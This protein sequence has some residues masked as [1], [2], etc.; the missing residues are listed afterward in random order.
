MA[1]DNWRCERNEKFNSNHAIFE[2]SK[3]SVTA[4]ECPDNPFDHNSV[5]Y[6]LNR[7]KRNREGL[8]MGSKLVQK[9]Q[10]FPID[11]DEIE[12]SADE[13]NAMPIKLSS[14]IKYHRPFPSPL[15][16]P[17]FVKNLSFSDTCGSRIESIII[18]LENKLGKNECTSISPTYSAETTGSLNVIKNMKSHPVHSNIVSLDE[19]SLPTPSSNSSSSLISTTNDF[20]PNTKTHEHCLPITRNP[21]NSS[22]QSNLWFNNLR[23]TKHTRNDDSLSEE[24]SD[25]SDGQPEYGSRLACERD[26]GSEGD[27]SSSDGI[28]DLLNYDFVEIKEEKEVH[29]DIKDEDDAREELSGSSLY[30]CGNDQCDYSSQNVTSFHDHLLVC[31]FSEVHFNCYHCSHIFEDVRDLLE[32][33]KIHGAKRFICSMCNFKSPLQTSAKSHFKDSHQVNQ[34]KTLPLIKGKNNPEKDSFVIMPKRAILSVQKSKNVK[35][36]FT[37]D[38]I[39]MIPLK[40]DIYQNPVRCGICDFS[41][42]IRSNIVK[43]LRRHAAGLKPPDITPVNPSPIFDEGF[44]SN[45]IRMKTN[46]NV[47]INSNLPTDHVKI[48]PLSDEKMSRLPE[49]ISETQRFTCSSS[50]CKYVTID[51]NMLYQHVKLRHKN[52]KIYNCPHCIN[53]N[54][55]VD[56]MLGHLHCHGDDLYTCSCCNFYHWQKRSVE[57]HVKNVHDGEN[58]VVVDARAEADIKEK[59]KNKKGTG[60]VLTC[61]PYKCGLCNESRKSIDEIKRHCFEEHGLNTQYKCLLC[62][63]TF[64]IKYDVENHIATDHKECS[65]VILKAYYVDPITFA[66]PANQPRISPLWKRQNRGVR[67]IRGI[68]LDENAD[69]QMDEKIELDMQNNVRKKLIDSKSTLAGH[70]ASW[71]LPKLYEGTKRKG[72]KAGEDKNENMIKKMKKHDD[73][74]NTFKKNCQAK[75]LELS[76]YNLCK[77][78]KCSY[79]PKISQNLDQINKHCH[80]FHIDKPFEYFVLT[81]DE[82]INL[83]TKEDRST[84]NSCHYSCFYCEELGDIVQL[85]THTKSIHPGKM[86]KVTNF[87]NSKV[88]IY[89]ECQLCGYLCREF[90]STIQQIHIEEE[91]PHGTGIMWDRYM[92][93][94]QVGHNAFTSPN[95]TFNFNTGE[96]EGLIFVCPYTSI[97]NSG[98]HSEVKCPFSTKNLVQINNHLRTHT[99]SYKCGYCEQ[100]FTD[101]SKFHEHSSLVHRNKIP[102]LVKDPDGDSE[103]EGLKGL[104]EWNVQRQISDRKVVNDE[105]SNALKTDMAE[106]GTVPGGRSMNVARKSTSLGTNLW[107]ETKTCEIPYSFYNIKPEYIDLKNVKTRITLG[108]QE[109]MVN[110]KQIGQFFNMEPK[111]VLRDCQEV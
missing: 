13:I 32:H 79:C 12:M 71:K 86:L 20:Y 28:N 95:Q 57:K 92:S 100:T 68:P 25:S 101:S 99:R 23:E 21:L 40:P 18:E 33:V 52:L 108:N 98:I 26:E 10:S 42:K 60:L 19:N 63:E 3:T 59:L 47:G 4:A 103:Y 6:D 72:I 36:V 7:L 29:E 37:P 1:Q 84:E 102:D 94:K 87:Q 46:N 50:G 53:V 109:L 69:D 82:M 91:H 89:L 22:I 75:S 77:S 48:V 55:P 9:I 5:K 88:H 96:A 93:K 54:I 56:T 44:E 11:S 104:L 76:P 24:S 2:M 97:P 106:S 41:T 81:R 14:K 111:L 67:Q 31:E 45:Y 65:P 74:I 85:E 34:I 107:H 80:D 27:S 17:S 30:M 105:S 16:T 61:R 64:N 43:H 15:P 49:L 62:N 66:E 8:Q 38:T 39:D 51:G 78:Y 83:I 70:G 58:V 110:I 73:N 90:D 35:C